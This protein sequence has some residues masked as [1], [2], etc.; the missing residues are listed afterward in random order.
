MSDEP[1][2]PELPETGDER[3][4]LRAWLDFH[5][6]TF[7]RKLRG[8]TP[9]QLIQRAAPPSDMS[10]LGLLRH[11]AETERYLFDVLFRGGVERPIFPEGEWAVD[12]AG[13]EAS[14]ADA[15]AHWRHWCQYT[16]DVEGAAPSLDEISL[17]PGLFDEDRPA[18]LRWLM[19]HAVEEYARHNGHADLLR[20]RID[21]TTGW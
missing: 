21:G 12:D 9:E 19:F 17:G 2:R 4:L 18:S 6:A 14:V 13:T 11:H 1:S 10:L 16:R 3:T 8:L 7:E 20:E 15:L 5:R